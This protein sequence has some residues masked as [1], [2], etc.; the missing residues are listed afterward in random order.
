MQWFELLYVML[1]AYAANMAPVLCRKLPWSAP[2]DFGMRVRGERLLG[3]HKTWRGFVCGVCA[4]LL[5]GLIMQVY[6]P[7]DI[8][9]IYWSLLAGSGALFGDS[10]KSFFKRRRSIESGKPWIPFDQLDYSIGA[11]L[12]GA[13]IFFPGWFEAIFIIG[14]SLVLHVVVN[15]VAFWLKIRDEKW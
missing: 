3:A 7:F 9:L 13:I 4:A 8:H 1:P 6:W 12:F 2:V 14:A 10:V 11:L 5:T 15:H